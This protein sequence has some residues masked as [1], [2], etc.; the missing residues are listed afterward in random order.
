M[1]EDRELLKQ[2]DI[3]A[4]YTQKGIVPITFIGDDIESDNATNTLYTLPYRSMIAM[5]LSG[6]D[7]QYDSIDRRSVMD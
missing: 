1:S 2:N 6:K 7:L 5:Q 4:A 3:I